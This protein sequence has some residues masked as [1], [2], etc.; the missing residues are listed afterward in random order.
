MNTTFNLVKKG[1]LALAGIF[2]VLLAY[3]VMPLPMANPSNCGAVVGKVESVK[4]GDGPG[5]ILVT[6]SG[7]NDYY[8]INRGLEN[9]IRLEV[10]SKQLVDKTAKVYYIKHWSLLNFN[11]KTRHIARIEVGEQLVYNEW[12]GRS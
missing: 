6:F 9:G 1:L 10:L 2:L 7:D 8:Y 5:D 11:S 4:A 12:K 3:S